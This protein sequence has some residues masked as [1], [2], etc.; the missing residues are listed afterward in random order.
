MPADIPVNVHGEP[1]TADYHLIKSKLPTWLIESRDAGREAFKRADSRHLNW[2]VT[3]TGEGQGMA[4]R[5]LARGLFRLDEVERTA[6]ADIAARTAEI[7]Q[8]P[9]LSAMR[10]QELIDLLEEVEIRLAYRM[11]LKGKDRLDLPGQPKFARFTSLANVSQQTLD[12]T[13]TRIIA[14]NNSPQE[15]EAQPLP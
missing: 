9:G 6:L 11:G 8:R 14:L 1:L 4:L 2:L 10:R 5:T 3:A 15:L 12:A 13:Y 7:N